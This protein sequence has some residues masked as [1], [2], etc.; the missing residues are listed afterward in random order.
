MVADDGGGGEDARAN[1]DADNKGEAVEVGKGVVGG[2]EGGGRGWGEGF[3]VRERATARGSCVTNTT[4]TAA[5]ALQQPL[6]LRVCC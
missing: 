6:A 1:L 5:V 2:S 3:I 4:I